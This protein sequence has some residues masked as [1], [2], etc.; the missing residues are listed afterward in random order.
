MVIGLNVNTTVGGAYQLKIAAIKSIPDLFDIWLKDDYLKDSLDVKHNPTYNFSIDLKDAASHDP[1]RFSLIMRQNPALGLRLLNFAGT[2]ASAT[3]AQLTWKTENEVNYTNFTVERSIDKGKTFE[4]VG[5]FASSALGTYSLADAKPAQTSNQYRLKLED[6]NGDITY[7]K[8]VTLMFGPTNNTITK[9]DISIY[10]NP[11]RS[12]I[13]LSIPQSNGK[14]LYNIQIVNNTGAIMKS[15]TSTQ[16]TWQGD[17]SNLLP[18]TYILRVINKT[19]NSLV[20]R[21][22]FVKL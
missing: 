21:S 16:A 15:V 2:K 5:G 4:V 10:P 11:A 14:P 3:S 19:D 13:N 12:N 7:S 9:N 18:G 1:K 20:G 6:I 8:I 17:V 22:T